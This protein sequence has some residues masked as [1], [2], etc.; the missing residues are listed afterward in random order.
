MPSLFQTLSSPPPKFNITS[1]PLPSY[2]SSSHAPSRKSP[3]RVIHDAG[4]IHSATVVIPD[5]LYKL[6][7]DRIQPETIKA[8]Y[9][10]VIIK[11]EDVLDG[12]F[13]TQYIKRGES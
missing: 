10:K 2:V 7:W 5:E 3:W 13:F 4:F 9:A 1:G 6:I 8:T 11:L 12:D